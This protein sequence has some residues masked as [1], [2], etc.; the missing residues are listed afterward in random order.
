[1]M[2]LE[3]GEEGVTFSALASG[4]RDGNKMR[5]LGGPSP[6]SSGTG[7][8]GG[9]GGGSLQREW[10]HGRDDGDWPYDGGGGSGDPSS[11]GPDGHSSSK[12]MNLLNLYDADAH[13]EAEEGELN[14]G[15]RGQKYTHGLLH[16]HRVRLGL[17]N[18]LLVAA[19]I[20]GISFAVSSG[21]RES[22]KEY[23]KEVDELVDEL[24]KGKGGGDGQ[25]AGRQGVPE[26]SPEHA[27]V[28]STTDV[29]EKF[30]GDI[31]KYAPKLFDR[32]MGWSGKTYL[33][34]FRFCKD[35]TSKDGRS[36]IYEICPYGAVCPLGPD[37]FPVIG[38]E[39]EDTSW[40]P[41]SDVSND[42][43][44]IGKKEPCDRYSSINEF[45]PEWGIDGD[46]GDD[47]DASSTTSRV[48]CCL[49]EGYLLGYD[50]GLMTVGR[51]EGYYVGWNMAETFG[52][53]NPSLPLYEEMAQE[54]EVLAFDRS[55]GWTGMTYIE[56]YDLCGSLQDYGL[57]PYGVVCPLVAP[58]A[59]IVGIKYEV[60]GSWAPIAGDDWVQLGQDMPCT[61]YSSSFSEQ[62]S[63]SISGVG[64][65][66][67][68]RHILCCKTHPN[69]TA[70]TVSPTA[71]DD[72][73]PVQNDKTENYGQLY[74][75]A[76]EIFQPKEF[77]RNTGWNG[78]TYLEAVDFCA[79]YKDG[80]NVCPYEAICPYGHDTEPVS[81]H[82][83]GIDGD[84]QWMPIFDMVN[85][86]VAINENESC[87]RFS[88]MNPDVPEW[89]VTG[90]GSEGITRH[91][92]CC[93]LKK[94]VS[95]SLGEAYNDAIEEHDPTSYTREDGWYGQTYEDAVIFCSEMKGVKIC[96]Y[97]A[98]CPLGPQQMPLW[99]YDKWGGVPGQTWAPISD[100][101]DDFVQLSAG[102]NACV[103]YSAIHDAAPDWGD[104]GEQFTRN[105]VCCEGSIL[106]DAEESF[107]YQTA[108]TTYLP[109]RYNR[110]TGYMG[111]TYQDAVSFCSAKSSETFLCPYE[112][113]EC[114]TKT[115]IPIVFVQTVFV[116][117]NFL[118]CCLPPF[119][120]L[121][122]GRLR[123]STRRC[124]NRRTKWVLGPDQQ[125]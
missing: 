22:T 107:V 74:V 116:V 93:L 48:L 79:S 40:V 87:L 117:A 85:D 63:W 12:S 121:P 41:I 45:P 24:A 76:V 81:G 89:G 92:L 65:E 15:P 33:D 64:S 8:T 3:G 96:P 109:I 25:E 31:A 71:A 51:A 20:F 94:D 114:I 72:E 6:S 75:E 69:P 125:Q 54:F 91:L 42:W 53:D 44:N 123:C 101:G 99:G 37:S 43:A 70:S 13:D 82:G 106:G 19:V 100:T 78:S 113:C 14:M 18:C 59:P 39:K 86:W 105:I 124:N 21:N 120:R 47:D 56:A 34:A 28:A 111:Q 23:G 57:C 110:L 58:S 83:K 50:T 17:M 84:Q 4:V 55:R 27:A 66:K 5:L 103:R 2:L 122:H 90:E 67:L 36:G 10:S 112:A 9:G 118:T 16:S 80:F 52:H 97:R 32:E 35:V 30:E 46:G 29:D 26:T 104:S 108:A 95:S 60:N 98:L 61:T 88:A 77:D 1:M 73:Y 11:S 115:I 49:S 102:E 68:T 62:P 119:V 7:G 38:F